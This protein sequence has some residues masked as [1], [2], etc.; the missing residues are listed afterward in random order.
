MIGCVVSFEG[1]PIRYQG[2]LPAAP[3]AAKL[4]LEDPMNLWLRA[5]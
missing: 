2:R 3:G 5:A 1:R 4:G